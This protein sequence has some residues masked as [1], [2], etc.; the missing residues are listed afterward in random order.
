MIIAVILGIV[1]QGKIATFQGIAEA[2]ETIISVPSPTEVVKVHVMP[3]QSINAGDTI[4]ELNRP[5]LTLRIAEVTRELDASEGRS[6]LSAADI[7]QKVAAVKADLATKTLTL[8]SEINRLESEY[9]K[10][11]EIASK[12]KSLKNSNS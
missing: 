7:D 6:N 9:K 10:N 4:V 8:K 1:Y 11:K 3:G 5:D 2:T 12:L